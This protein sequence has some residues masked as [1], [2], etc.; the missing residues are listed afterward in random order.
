MNIIENKLNLTAREYFNYKCSDINAVQFY[1]EL[2]EQLADQTD[3]FQD[4]DDQ[5]ERLQ[6]ENQRLQ[7]EI[8]LLKKENE[9]YFLNS[10]MLE[11]D[12]YIEPQN[13]ELIVVYGKPN[14]FNRL[15]SCQVFTS[16]GLKFIEN[17]S[18]EKGEHLGK[19]ISFSDLSTDAQTFVMQYLTVV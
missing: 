11:N 18:C 6:A 15:Y 19:Q 10:L 3:S 16:D 12:F 4:V 13:N 8:A 17:S 9:A 5:V 1:F 14:K 2:E 7:D